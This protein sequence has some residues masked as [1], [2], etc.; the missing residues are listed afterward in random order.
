MDQLF[1]IQLLTSFIFGGGVIALLSFI[2]ERVSSR[3]AGII[4][5][6]PTTIA[7]GFFFLGWALSPQ[8]VAN[9]VPAILIPMG[10]SV[11]FA[12]IYSYVAEYSAKIINNKTWQIAV[13]FLVSIGIWLALDVL[14]IALELNSLEVGVVGYFLVILIAHLLLKRKN[15]EKPV[16]LKYTLSQKIGRAIFIGIVIALVVFFG[17]TLGS[18]WGGIFATFP[19]AF[20][21]L[22]M[23]L[24]WYY[25]PKS[26]FPT[27]QKAA[28]GSVS[29]F[30][31]AIAVMLIFPRIGFFIGTIFA[32]FISLVVTLLLAK[33]QPNSKEI[34]PSS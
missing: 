6:F 3:T 14:V 9:I 11:L 33:F 25:G 26:L 5:A 29:I 10:I 28:I 15:Y 1:I 12:A 18:F 2:A 30:A 27:M 34:F 4:I 31:Y 24:H 8:A 20:S 19:A 7:L 23:I 21:S 16:F 22:M 17:K 13:S 32:Y